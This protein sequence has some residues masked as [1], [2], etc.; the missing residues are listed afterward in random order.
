MVILSAQNSDTNINKIAPAIF[1]TYPNMESLAVC[2]VEAQIP[3]IIKVKNFGTKA[4]WLIEI[5]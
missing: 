5:T 2:N 3:F 1:K 4:S